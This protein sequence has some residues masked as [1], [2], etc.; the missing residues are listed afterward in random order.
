M[1]PPRVRE[2]TKI[3]LTE[4]RNI[5]CRGSGKKFRGKVCIQD[6]SSKSYLLGFLEI[7]FRQTKIATHLPEEE[8]Q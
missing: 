8:I 2:G 4:L 5:G 7:H 3:H 1:R 6:L